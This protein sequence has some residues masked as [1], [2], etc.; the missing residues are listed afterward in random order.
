LGTSTSKRFLLVLT[1]CPR[2]STVGMCECQLSLRLVNAHPY[3]ALT[4][5]SISTRTTI[6]DSL[7]R[8]RLIRTTDAQTY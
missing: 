1:G 6:L 4:N 8:L 2:L 7:Y 3:S 5:S